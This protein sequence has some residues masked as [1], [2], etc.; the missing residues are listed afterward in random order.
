MKAA[1][2]APITMEEFKE[3]LPAH[4]RKTVVPELLDYINA[5]IADPEILAVY[6]ENVLGLASVLKE[7]KFKI[8]DYLS[9]VKFVSHKLLGDNQITAWAKTFPD[10]YNAACARGNS[11]SEIAA[12]CSRYA[13]SK[14]VILLLGQTIMPTHIL[15]APLYQEAINAQAELMRSAKSEKVRCDAAANL[16]MTLK[17]PE[18]KKVELS[19]GIQEDESIGALRAST[20]ELARL[21]RELIESGQLSVRSI[22]ESKLI[23]SSDTAGKVIDIHAIS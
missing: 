22:A 7:G 16:I 10:R 14:L 6:R 13:S 2:D 11:R 12:V 4:I 21:Q 1:H 23:G 18:V 17:P 20:L 3:C 5:G 8:N 9:A 19:L 15:N